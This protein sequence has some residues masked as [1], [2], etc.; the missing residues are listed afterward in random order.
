MLRP[1]KKDSGEHTT[2]DQAG[3]IIALQQERTHVPECRG[4]RKNTGIVET[5]DRPESA[6]EEV[7]R[8]VRG[9]IFRI[10][11]CAELWLGFI[12]VLL[13]ASRAEWTGVVCL[14][15]VVLHIKVCVMSHG[16]TSCG[17]Y[18]NPRSLS[19]AGY[20]LNL[21][22]YKSRRNNSAGLSREFPV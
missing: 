16:F 5:A 9:L 21:L 12:A 1:T 15:L 7:P 13:R 11:T 17:F 10:R 2:I 3:F 14:D 4:V 8:T 22:Y 19:H 6:S 20:K 18:L